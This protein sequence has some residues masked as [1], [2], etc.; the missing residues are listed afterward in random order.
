M[1][2]I[3]IPRLHTTSLHHDMLESFKMTSKLIKV[4]LVLIGIVVA[5]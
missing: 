3:N 5:K 1:A 2:N 4:N